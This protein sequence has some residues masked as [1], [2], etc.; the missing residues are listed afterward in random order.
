MQRRP[1]RAL[2]LSLNVHTNSCDLDE[3]LPTWT[4]RCIQYKHECWCGQNAPSAR[5]GIYLPARV[6]PET[7]AAAAAT[8]VAAVTVASGVFLPSIDMGE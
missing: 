3:P 4:L 5:L 7:E 6:R 8:E 1:T 2:C